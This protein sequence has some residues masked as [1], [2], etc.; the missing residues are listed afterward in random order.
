MDKKFLLYID[1]LGFSKLVSKDISRVR[2]LYRIIEKLNVHHH[3][4]FHVIVFSDTILIY[5]IDDPFA[6]F[7]RGYIVMFLI[8]FVQ[9]LLY[10]CIGKDYYFRAVLVNGEFKHTTLK[11]IDCIFG[12]ALINA[13]L[14]EKAINCTGLF[15]DQYCQ[16]YNIVFP[17]EPYDAKLSFVY[18]NQSLER[19]YR[20]ELGKWPVD[21]WI[22]YDTDSEWHLAKDVRFLKDVHRLMHQHPDSKVRGKM[23]ATWNYYYRRYGK[24]LRELES[25]N[26]DLKVL[27]KGFDWSKAKSRI[28]ED[29]RGFGVS[30]P[31]MKKF[32]NIIQEAREA[33]RI[34]AVKALKKVYGDSKPNGRLMTL[35]GGARMILDVD[36][37]TQLG[38]FLKK[39]GD[40]IQ[41]VSISSCYRHKGFAIHI[42]N[43]HNGQERFVYI[44]ASESA[45][46]VLRKRLRIDGFVESYYD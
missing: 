1:I 13:Y 16:K 23:F 19:F 24:L 4:Y 36:G 3:D 38:K 44:K 18:L 26:F 12:K 33:G 27:S 10:N 7:N 32:K 29:Y 34:A 22:M 40:S 15:I 25:Q 2:R 46:A 28:M 30:P 45:M 21:P 20:G 37:R 17:V 11:N 8:E 6:E 41:G 9:N 39:V 42:N 43:I 31:S 14:K 5:N 35:C